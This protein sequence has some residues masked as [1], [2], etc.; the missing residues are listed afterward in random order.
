VIAGTIASRAR[1]RRLDLGESS[2]YLLGLRQAWPIGCDLH[3]SGLHPTALATGQ[4]G[5]QR[6]TANAET[7]L[8]RRRRSRFGLQGHLP[9]PRFATARAGRSWAGL[10]TRWHDSR[11]RC[12]CRES[13]CPACCGTREQC[14]R[15]HGRRPFYL[16]I[17][18][19]RSP[20]VWHAVQGIDMGVP[21]P[22]A[23][24][25]HAIGLAIGT[26]RGV[27]RAHVVR[28]GQWIRDRGSRSCS[29]TGPWRTPVAPARASTT[30]ANWRW[31]RLR[32]TIRDGFCTDR[33]VHAWSCVS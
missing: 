8:Y 6:L 7:R 20:S 22:Q 15:V 21:A 5:V 4:F 23:G 31:I 19:R 16:E 32:S 13:T 33:K 27:R 17:S 18:I 28:P 14:C 2:Q 9:A 29:S 1:T 25:R 11:A 3:R 10:T 12:R 24:L 26:R 30:L